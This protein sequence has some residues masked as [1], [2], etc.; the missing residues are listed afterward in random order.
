MRFPARATWLVA[1]G[2]APTWAAA[3]TAGQLPAPLVPIVTPLHLFPG[4]PTGDRG[5]LAPFAAVTPL[6]LSLMGGIVPQAHAYPNCAS[7]EDPSGNSVSG[8]PILRYAPLRLTQHLTLHGFSSGG[9]PV[10][11]GIGGALTYTAPIKPNLWVVGGIGTY[12]LPGLDAVRPP[13][14][15][16]D[17]HIDLVQQAGS[18]SSY[19]VGLRRRGITFSGN[20]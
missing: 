8:F 18:G 14:T 16:A 4:E 1:F 7:R 9:C 15:R 10:D 2:L 20:F 11:A 3:Q 12:H 19:A 6:R 5:D 17:F 13:V